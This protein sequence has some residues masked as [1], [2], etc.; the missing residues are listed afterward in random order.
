MREKPPAA[1]GAQ[2]RDWDKERSASGYQL[3]GLGGA[4]A[5]LL[6]CALR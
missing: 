6:L 1:Q 5:E 3:L 4:C 2:V